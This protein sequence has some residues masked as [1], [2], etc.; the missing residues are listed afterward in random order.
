[1]I[2]LVRG[3]PDAG[4]PAPCVTAWQCD[5]RWLAGGL[6]GGGAS[7]RPNQS[8]VADAAANS[9]SFARAR[10]RR[11]TF[12]MRRRR[13]S[14]RR[15][16]APRL[17]QSPSVPAAGRPAVPGERLSSPLPRHRRPCTGVRSRRAPCF[18]S[19]G[20]TLSRLRR[21]VP[22][23]QIAATRRRGGG[24]TRAPLHGGGGRARLNQRTDDRTDVKDGEEL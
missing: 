6:A 21:S 19:A 2:V 4:R 17:R 11:R 8:S 13:K 24:S 1:M 22:G 23:G 5:R 12:F 20:G 18:F 16:G 10:A 15:G 9:N 7:R 14:G 3:E